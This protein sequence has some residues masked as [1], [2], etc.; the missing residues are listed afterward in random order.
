[1]ALPIAKALKA[2]VTIGPSI[3][4]WIFSDG[5]F[6]TKRAAILLIALVILMIGYQLIP[7]EMVH[8]IDSLDQV[9]DM[10]GYSDLSQ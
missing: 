6:Q 3:K 8:I 2:L 4:Q 10:I 9:S 1:M 7:H 5:K